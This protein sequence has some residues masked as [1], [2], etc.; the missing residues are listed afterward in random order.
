M[1]DLRRYARQTN[2]RLIV[3]GVLILF[4]VGDG[5][6]FLIFGKNAAILGLAC[7]LAGLSPLLLIW[8]SLGLMDWLVKRQDRLGQVGNGKN[9]NY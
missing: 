3:G 4:I 1:R 9:K 7:L 8:I 6:I 2:T 5:L